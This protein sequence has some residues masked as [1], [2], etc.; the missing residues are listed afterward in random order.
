MTR[1]PISAPSERPYLNLSDDALRAEYLRVDALFDPDAVHDL[2]EIERTLFAL[3]D[4][5]CM[6]GLD[7][8]RAEVAPKQMSLL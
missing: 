5:L 4:E 7:I 1:T 2:V 3:D 6:R 8:P